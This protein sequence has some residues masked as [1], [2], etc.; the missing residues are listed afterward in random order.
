M[1]K[2]FRAEV[3]GRNQPQKSPTRIA[4]K[5]ALQKMTRGGRVIVRE[6]GGALGPRVND[7]DRLQSRSVGANEL[8][9]RRLAKHKRPTEKDEMELFVYDPLLP[10]GGVR[11]D[12]MFV[13]RTNSQV[14]AWCACKKRLSVHLSRCEAACFVRLQH[15]SGPRHQGTRRAYYKARHEVR[16]PGQSLWIP[17]L[18]SRSSR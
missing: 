10:A 4:V 16:T 2:G 11:Y 7:G 9:E 1:G 12:G 5:I 17:G 6:K 15:M 14:L 8:P 3:D 13:E 18:G